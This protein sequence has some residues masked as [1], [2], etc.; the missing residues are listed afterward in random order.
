MTDTKSVRSI[1]E[2]CRGNQIDIPDTSGLYA[3][4]WIGDRRELLEAQLLP[5]N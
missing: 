3:F 4:W 2:I 1:A 5:E